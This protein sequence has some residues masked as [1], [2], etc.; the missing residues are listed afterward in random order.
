MSG[1]PITTTITTTGRLRRRSVRRTTPHGAILPSVT[2]KATPPR[3]PGARRTTPSARPDLPA[4]RPKPT[5]RTT[6]D[7]A[8]QVFQP[9]NQDAAKGFVPLP[10]LAVLR[11]AIPDA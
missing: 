11:N 6:I 3:A 7:L 4:Q 10:H 2:D 1:T 9:N 5:N 8:K